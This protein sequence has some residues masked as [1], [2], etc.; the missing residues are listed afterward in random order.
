[1]SQNYAL[2]WGTL[3]VFLYTW[4]QVQNKS[5]WTAPLWTYGA[6]WTTASCKVNR[7]CV[8]TLVFRE[9]TKVLRENANIFVRTQKFWVNA[10]IYLWGNAKVLQW[11]ANIF[12]RECKS[13]AR[14]CKVSQRNKSFARERFFPLPYPFRGSVFLHSAFHS[15]WHI[16][17]PFILN[18]WKMPA[19]TYVAQK[20][21][22]KTWGWVNND[23]ICIFFKCRTLYLTFVLE[24]MGAP[25]SSNI[26]TTCSWPLLAPQCKGVRPSWRFENKHIYITHCPAGKC[27]NLQSSAIINITIHP[28]W[29]LSNTQWKTAL[30]YW[31]QRRAQHL[32]AI[33]LRQWCQT[34]VTWGLRLLS[35]IRI[36]QHVSLNYPFQINYLLI[37]KRI[38]CSKKAAE[39]GHKWI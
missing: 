38:V 26:S 8:Q 3:T 25:R 37:L 17:F 16:K 15:V 29:H 13:F 24:R 32:H 2:N 9:N 11:N 30:L 34:H 20:K 1:M 12:A 35:F 39:N 5:L 18:I 28:M 19:L 31:R 36:K 22:G 27:Q 7:K 4:V 14:E 33:S 21:F 23:R 10:N 6:V